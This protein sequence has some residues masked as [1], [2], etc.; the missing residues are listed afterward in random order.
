MV[1]QKQVNEACQMIKRDGDAITVAKVRTL[2]GKKHSFFELADKVLLY[3]DDP[4][5]AKKIAQSEKS[6][7]CNK[8]KE[9][10]MVGVIDQVLKDHDVA[11]HE[12]LAFKLSEVLHHDIK[13]R[14][15][16]QTK[17]CQD[18]LLKVRR[19]ND[20]I[21][22][23]YYGLKARFD[24]LVQT[25]QKL[26]EEH[27]KLQQALQNALAR[28]KNYQNEIE[29]NKPVQMRDY[30]AQMS[31]LEGNCCA[32]YDPRRKQ[33]V[34]KVPVKHKLIKE[35][36]KGQNSIHLRAD[37]TFDFA[38]KYWFLDGFEAKTIQLLMRNDFVISKELST[39]LQYLQA[40]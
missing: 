33:I 25:H 28:R 31:L 21:E 36:E 19:A 13:K 23:R 16:H 30:Q 29:D 26:E 6:A 3:K 34:V 11:M 10:G 5:L 38:S 7:A 1:T 35:F 24:A 40:Q 12:A 2:L 39:V 8:T 20:H 27:Y 37:A 4:D 9:T 32:G 22:V 17:Q 14:I 15:S 18:T